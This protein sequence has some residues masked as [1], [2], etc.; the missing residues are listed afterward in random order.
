[1]L[2]FL[3]RK[4][5]MWL[6][7]NTETAQRSIPVTALL[8][9]VGELGIA[10]SIRLHM[11]YLILGVSF[12]LQTSALLISLAYFFWFAWVA[13]CWSQAKVRQLLLTKQQA[14]NKGIAC[15]LMLLAGLLLLT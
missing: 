2:S 1:M 14:V 4:T 10:L 6:L 15:V 3:A 9:A 11:A 7:Y 12:L 5:G 13:L 8:E